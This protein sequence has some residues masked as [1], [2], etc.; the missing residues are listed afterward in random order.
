[1][2]YYLYSIFVFY[3]YQSTST[4]I[5]PELIIQCPDV[6][7]RWIN[8]NDAKSI[9]AR[10]ATNTALQD[11]KQAAMRKENTHQYQLRTFN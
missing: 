11:F 6:K 3:F 10:A 2:R 8:I 7:T 1:M 5:K 4:K 9:S